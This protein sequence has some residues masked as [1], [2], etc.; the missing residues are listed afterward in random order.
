VAVIVTE[1]IAASPDLVWA[2]M[3]D[4]DRWPTWTESVRTAERLDDGPLAIGS[5]A[6]LK[7][8]GM[9]PMVWEVTECVASS[10]FAWRTRTPGVTTV[11]IHRVE[12]GPD[13]HSTLTLEVHHSGPLAGVIGAL[14]ASRT[15]RF[16]GME[17][18]GLKKASE[19]RAAP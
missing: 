10:V 3:A 9:P 17:A 19:E 15:N 8:P 13:G 4:I 12:P 14:T 11:G 5:R 16:M 18:A 2:V 6:R 7:Q 1:Q